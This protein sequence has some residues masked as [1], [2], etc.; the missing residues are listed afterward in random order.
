[1][2][3]SLATAGDD[4]LVSCVFSS[5]RK[6]IFKHPQ[7]NEHRERREGKLGAMKW[8][9]GGVSG[10][11]RCGGGGAGGQRCGGGRQQSMS[12]LQI[13]RGLLKRL[14]PKESAAASAHRTTNSLSWG[15]LVFP[16]ER[17][18]NNYAG[19]LCM[20]HLIDVAGRKISP[21]PKEN[22]GTFVM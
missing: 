12:A 1:M 10:M 9:W 14:N 19:K 3:T 17:R 21:H 11:G 16:S 5:I 2:P 7:Q 15:W 13:W 22:A 20:L 8:G 18:T 4:Q 6:H